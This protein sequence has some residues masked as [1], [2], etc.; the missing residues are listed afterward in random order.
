MCFI[1]FLSSIS[2]PPAAT[3]YTHTDKIIHI[4]E[5][6]LLGF[7][8]LAGFRSKEIAMGNAIILAVT[9]AVLYGLCDELHQSFVP[10]RSMSLSD[11]I[12]DGIGAM[13][14]VAAG[15]LK[16]R[17]GKFDRETRI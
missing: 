9:V 14:G 6:S 7:L 8:L 5:Y 3:H 10:G 16:Y 13:L 15:N 17:S 11:V 1:F 12:A 2:H 4:L